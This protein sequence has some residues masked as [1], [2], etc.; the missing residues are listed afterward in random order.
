MR[1]LLLVPVFALALSGCYD[2]QLESFGSSVWWTGTVNFATSDVTLSAGMTELQP[3]TVDTL[4]A[5]V[6]ATRFGV[7]TFDRVYELETPADE[8]FSFNIVAR[9]AANWGLTRIEVGHV[10]ANGLTTAL[11]SETIAGAGM[12]LEAPGM[13]NSGDVVQVNGDGFARVTV[14][15]KIQNEQVLLAK[16]PLLGSE[17]NIGIRIKIGTQTAINLSAANPQGF[18]P[19]MTT[20]DIYSSDSRQFGLPSIAVSGDRYSVVMYDGDP[21]ATGYVYRKR[22]WL[23]MDAQTNTVTGGEAVAYSPDSGFWRDQEIA[24]KGNVLA[25]A[26]TGNGALRTEISLDR[27]ASFPLESVVDPAANFGTRLAQIA[28]TPDYTLGVVYWRSFSYSSQLMLVEGTPTGFNTNND[29]TGYS[30]GNPVV[31]HN[32]GTSVVP[33]VMQ[34]EYSHGGDAVIGYGYTR[35]TG[36][37]AS[38]R[39]RCAVRLWGGTWTDKLVDQ[40]DFVMPCDPH[41]SLLGTG[42]SMEI[43]YTY[44]KDD[45]VYLWYSDDASTSFT[46][47]HHVQH[48]GT[49]MPSVHARMQGAQKRVDLIYAAPD[50]W[51]MELHNKQWDDF[52]L[53][54]APTEWRITQSTAVPGGNPPA[55]MPQGWDIS[56]MGWFGYDAVLKGDDVAIVYHE[57]TYG[58]YEYYWAW[59]WQWN[60]PNTGGGGSAAGGASG[61]GGSGYTPPPTPT[62]LLPGMSGSVPAPDPNHRNQLKI[63]VLD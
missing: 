18:R 37:M 29:P 1:K 58:S 54:A 50:G 39:Y 14:R 28:I 61:S 46:L 43:F 56:T 42:T 57:L 34:L 59:G 51:G 36:A 21:Q 27:G 24:A 63:A 41:V 22:R 10:S 48:P 12:T 35:W 16:A 2:Y 31:I 47:A 45:G 13:A 53:T 32:P 52:T 40:E 5:S 30:W 7:N 8:D 20:T 19:G 4:S 17:I 49:A 38:A 44:E 33:L 62:I 15:G 11:G 6:N 60:Q 25:V 23:Q 9:G 55:G 26:Y 3:E